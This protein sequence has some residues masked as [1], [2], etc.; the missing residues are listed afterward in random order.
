MVFDD[1]VEFGMQFRG[2]GRNVALHE[3]LKSAA[4][5]RVEQGRGDRRNDDPD[6]RCD[7]VTGNPTRAASGPYPTIPER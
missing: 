7:D 4:Q 2:A 5:G 6:K 1:V 3:G